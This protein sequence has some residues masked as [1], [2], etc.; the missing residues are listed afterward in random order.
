MN[1]SPA[2]PAEQNIGLIQ[3]NNAY[4]ADAI[5]GRMVTDVRVGSIAAR[6]AGVTGVRLWHDQLLYKPDGHQA[7]LGPRSNG[8]DADGE[9][10]FHQDLG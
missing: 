10:T 7:S 3:I 1:R 9:I 5:L 8:A 6:L 4:W 2:D